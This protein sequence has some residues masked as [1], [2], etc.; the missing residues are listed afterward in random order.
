[1]H[2]LGSAN[3]S[4]LYKLALLCGFFGCQAGIYTLDSVPYCCARFSLSPNNIKKIVSQ[5]NVAAKMTHA[6]TCGY[7]LRE[8]LMMPDLT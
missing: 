3:L 1:M 8:G 4:N 6:L 2:G 5:L 7:I